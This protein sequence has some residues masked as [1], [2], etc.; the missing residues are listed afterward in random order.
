M[1]SL[2]AS[3]SGGLR[4]D[5]GQGTPSYYLPRL[6]TPDDEGLQGLALFEREV[7][8]DPGEGP[9]PVGEDREDREGGASEDEGFDRRGTQD[10]SGTLPDARRGEAA[11]RMKKWGRAPNP[12]GPR[13]PGSRSGDPF[14]AR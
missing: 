10:P 12:C 4:G 13:L 7:L 1:A 6:W 14:L 8:P 3:A 5:E 2:T 11:E 9:P